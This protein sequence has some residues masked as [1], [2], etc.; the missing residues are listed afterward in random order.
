MI[1]ILLL[2]YPILGTRTHV[3]YR[4]FGVVLYLSYHQFY[5]L[6]KINVNGYGEAGSGSSFTRP[7]RAGCTGCAKR[8]S[9]PQARSNC[10]SP[11][12]IRPSGATPSRHR[13][14]PLLH[15][16]RTTNTRTGGATMP[17]A[18]VGIL[19]P[20]MSAN[21]R[22]WTSITMSSNCHSTGPFTAHLC[23]RICIRSLLWAL[24]LASE[25]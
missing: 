19:F 11:G 9:S 4:R 13:A 7:R 17:S 18:K 5:L 24:E 2:L 3:L 14:I 16:S 8:G 15:P 25:D 23:R 1:S 12:T 22:G 21:R 20:T 6:P 10:D